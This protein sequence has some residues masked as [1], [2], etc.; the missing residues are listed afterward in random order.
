MAFQEPNTKDYIFIDESNRVH[1]KNENAHQPAANVGCRMQQ[2][3][4]TLQTDGGNG[5]N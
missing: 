3:K 5:I 1:A 4:R 2:F